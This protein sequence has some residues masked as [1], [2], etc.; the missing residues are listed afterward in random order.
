MAPFASGQVLVTYARTLGT[1]PVFT[2]KDGPEQREAVSWAS[3]ALP[4]PLWKMTKGP[5]LVLFEFTD[6]QSESIGQ[7]DRARDTYMIQRQSGVLAFKATDEADITCPAT[8]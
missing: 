2:S 3:P 1:G 5:I 4:H 8:A 7:F 6:Q